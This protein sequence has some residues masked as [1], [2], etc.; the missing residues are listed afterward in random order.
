MAQNPTEPAIGLRAA[1]DARAG[2]VR[3]DAT[4]RAIL[5]V[6]Q[7]DARIAN[8]ELADRVH[9][10]PAPCLRRVKRLE[11]AGVIER[12]VALLAPASVDRALTAFVEVTL[13][14][15]TRDV[16]DSFEPALGGLPEVLECHLITGDADYLLKVTAADLDDYQSFLLD[17]L[18]RVPGVG[19]VKTL[20]SMKQVKRTTALPLTPRPARG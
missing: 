3:L 17:R 6:L 1:P 10:T 13:D 14:K 16:V 12:Y 7:E 8:N 18:I 5:E 11:Q 9:L 20:I 4:D 19:D 2:D 15:Q